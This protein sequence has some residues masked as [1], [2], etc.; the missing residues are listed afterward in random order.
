MDYCAEPLGPGQGEIAVQLLM[1]RA[2]YSDPGD[3]V[4]PFGPGACMSF[5]SV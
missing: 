3:Y 4:V 2:G 1:R 5:S